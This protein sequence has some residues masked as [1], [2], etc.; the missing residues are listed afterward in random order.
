V[1]GAVLEQ[2]W[3]VFVPFW[4]LGLSLGR[5]HHSDHSH[6]IIYQ[7]WGHTTPSGNTLTQKFTAKQKTV[8]VGGCSFF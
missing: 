7:W 6:N 5:D 3:L 2:C 8:L 4:F 1:L